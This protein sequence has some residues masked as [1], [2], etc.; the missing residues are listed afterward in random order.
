MALSEPLVIPELLQRWTVV[1]I[2]S[3]AHQ[4]EVLAGWREKEKKG[5]DHHRNVK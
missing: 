4:E 3:Q 1:G 5:E 2:D